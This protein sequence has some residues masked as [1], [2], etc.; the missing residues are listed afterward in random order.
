[1]GNK[2]K[3]II[4]IA[5]AAISAADEAK[6]VA[7]YL[8]DMHLLAEVIVNNT[9]IQDLLADSSIDLEKR[10]LALDKA[11]S[12]QI[13]EYAK[14]T[15]AL[16]LKNNALGRFNDLIEALLA[17]AREQANYNTCIITS[18]VEI[19]E[20]LQVKLHKALQAKFGN[21]LE[22]SYSIN[23]EIIGGLEIICG[24][25][26]YRSTIQSKLE[27]LQQHLVRIR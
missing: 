19:S 9:Q 27:Q 26:R 22:I 20:P 6:I 8:A 10:I 1:M 18:A 24:E 14:N 13:H 15:M 12:G 16:L 25:W 7:K 4:D 5:N 11:F 23:P 17:A 3:K 2:T 21:N